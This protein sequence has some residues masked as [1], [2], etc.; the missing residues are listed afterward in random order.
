MDDQALLRDIRNLLLI[1]RAAKIRIARG[2]K[3]EPEDFETHTNE[4]G[5]EFRLLT[6]KAAIKRATT[7]LKTVQKMVE[8]DS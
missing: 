3:G 2:Q 1:N 4:D 6:W 7:E 5:E 8:S